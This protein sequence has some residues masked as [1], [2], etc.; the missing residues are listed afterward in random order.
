MSPI[1]LLLYQT[2]PAISICS[3]F[4]HLVWTSRRQGTLYKLIFRQGASEMEI[5]C[6][7]RDWRQLTHASLETCSKHFRKISIVLG[8]N[9]NWVNVVNDCLRDVCS[10]LDCN[11][12]I[13]INDLFENMSWARHSFNNPCIIKLENKSY[14]VLFGL[15]PRWSFSSPP[16]DVLLHYCERS[17]ISGYILSVS[18]SDPLETTFGV[19]PFLLAMLVHEPFP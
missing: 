4:L 2:R 6:D 16:R 3:T 19:Y 18:N 13:W 11:F 15:P 17:V 12:N 14:L 10:W 8:P 9:T 1:Y 5:G 7:I